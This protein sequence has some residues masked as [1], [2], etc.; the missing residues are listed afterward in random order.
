MIIDD[1]I[2][3]YLDSMINKCFSILRNVPWC[4]YTNSSTCHY[5]QISFI[6]MIEYMLVFC[7]QRAFISLTLVQKFTYKLTL[8]VINHENSDQQS[9]WKRD[10]WRKWIVFGSNA[11]KKK[12][13]SC[14]SFLPK[15]KENYYNMW[16]VQW[17]TIGNAYL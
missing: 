17:M 7:T 12:N 2:E 9:N 1:N 11:R 15:N 8:T 13:Q 6:Y 5:E 14:M 4:E 16:C 10:C 3:F